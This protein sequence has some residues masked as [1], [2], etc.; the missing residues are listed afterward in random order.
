M[1]AKFQ[2][3]HVKCTK[4][5]KINIRYFVICNLYTDADPSLESFRKSHVII[6]LDSIRLMHLN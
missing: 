3:S 2:K 4:N 1:L 5:C 6:N